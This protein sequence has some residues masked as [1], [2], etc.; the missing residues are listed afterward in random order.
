MMKIGRITTGE[1]F[2]RDDS[3]ASKET[4]KDKHRNLRTFS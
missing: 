3:F 4:K 1:D 2:K